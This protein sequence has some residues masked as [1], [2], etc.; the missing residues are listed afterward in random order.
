M[1]ANRPLN[2]LK[3]SR[4][5]GTLQYLYTGIV[6]VHRTGSGM[7]CALADI[8]IGQRAFI[9][10]QVSRILFLCHEAFIELAIQL[11]SC[12]SFML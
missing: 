8:N 7:H 3:S 4:M 12:L 1:S 9:F 2:T 11:W 10:V 5:K 6:Y